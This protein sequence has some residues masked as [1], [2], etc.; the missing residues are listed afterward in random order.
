M[1][2]CRRNTASARPRSRGF[3]LIEALVAFSVLAIVLAVAF[4]VFSDGLRQESTAR[5][6]AIATA[7]A[8]NVIA[9]IEAS[10]SI[11]VGEETG[12]LDDGYVWSMIVSDDST[13]NTGRNRAMRPVEIGVSVRWDDRGRQREVTLRTIRLSRIQ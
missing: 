9:R 11:A 7:H 10:R 4:Q 13:E 12:V 6:F 2:R 3:T 8:E 1:S 5:R